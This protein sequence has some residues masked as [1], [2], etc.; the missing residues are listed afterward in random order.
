M[1]SEWKITYFKPD[2]LGSISKDNEINS[3]ADRPDKT[4]SGVILYEQK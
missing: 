2:K 3:V 4:N 1:N